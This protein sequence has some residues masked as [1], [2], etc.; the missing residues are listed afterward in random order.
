MWDRGVGQPRPHAAG[1]AEC[2]HAPAIGEYR[3]GRLAD[4]AADAVEHH[5][6]R[7]DRVPDLVG[8]IVAA[9]VDRVRGAER[10]PAF[11]TTMNALVVAC[12]LSLRGLPAAATTCASAA[13]ASCTNQAADTAG[14]GLERAPG[15]RSRCLW[16]AV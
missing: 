9:A 11:L 12:E 7:A 6:D 10:P 14:L 16:P 1:R 13:A 5:V 4:G 2:Q 3:E 8:P 15:H